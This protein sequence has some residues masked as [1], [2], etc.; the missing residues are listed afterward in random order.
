[1]RPRPPL[2]PRRLPRRHDGGRPPRAPHHGAGSRASV[3]RVGHSEAG[4]GGPEPRRRARGT[5]GAGRPPRPPP[6]A[7]PPPRPA[8]AAPPL[9]TSPRGLPPPP[10]ADRAGVTVH[11]L[12][13]PQPL[14]RAVVQGAGVL[15]LQ[16]ELEAK[17]TVEGSLAAAPS[18]MPPVGA[19]SPAVGQI[20]TG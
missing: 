18:R 17:R 1:G 8:A 9:A 10:R 4:G 3:L 20:S 12:V 6:P 13:A 14:D 11:H 15:R 5:G 7:R 16:E 19:P 2:A